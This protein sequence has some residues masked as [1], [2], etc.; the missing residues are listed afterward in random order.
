[1]PTFE[2]LGTELTIADDTS[3]IADLV[4]WVEVMDAVGE[5]LFNTLKTL[6]LRYSV[7]KRPVVV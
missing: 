1:M 2:F 6:M 5:T 3:A 4:G 7:R